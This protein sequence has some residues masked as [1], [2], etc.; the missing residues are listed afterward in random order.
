MYINKVSPNV[1]E[2]A[3][4][5]LEKDIQLCFE[6]TGNFIYKIWN[7]TEVHSGNVSVWRRLIQLPYDLLTQYKRIKLLED[8]LTDY[9]ILLQEVHLDEASAK[10]ATSLMLALRTMVYAAKDIKDVMHNIKEMQGSDEAQVKELFE[11]LKGFVSGQ[12]GQMKAYIAESGE[13]ERPDWIG[14][15][16]AVYNLAIEELYKKGSRSQEIP[17]STLTNVIKQVVSS[18]DNLGNSVIHWRHMEKLVIDQVEGAE[19]KRDLHDEMI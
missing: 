17:V 14:I 2:A 12:L 11:F 9:H 16:D 3:L 8:E 7:G 15:H 5:A 4:A 13:K 1:P 10:K 6:L 18:L 19:V